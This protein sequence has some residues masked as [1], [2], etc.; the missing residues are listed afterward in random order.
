M[1]HVYAVDQGLGLQNET[2]DAVHYDDAT[3]LLLIIKGG[4][5]FAYDLSTSAGGGVW[6]PEA[7]PEG[8]GRV[9]DR[10]GT[11][12]RHDQLV[13]TY[14]LQEGPGVR[15]MRC[16]LDRQM[17]ALCRSLSL[18]EL[19]DLCTG[20]ISVHTL[21]GGTPTAPPS[22]SP[23]SPM[24]P[25][26][27]SATISPE[28]RPP[29]PLSPA[30]LNLTWGRL[31]GKSRSNKA[32]STGTAS[33]HA[34]SNTGGGGTGDLRAE[35]GGV[36]W[37]YVTPA[38]H[39][40]VTPPLGGD[41]TTQRRSSPLAA[42]VSASSPAAST[43]GAS[44]QGR[45]PRSLDVAEGGEGALGGNGG[46]GTKGGYVDKDGVYCSRSSSS[47]V[48]GGGGSSVDGGTQGSGGLLG[49]LMG[50]YFGAGSSS[51]PAHKGPSPSPAAWPLS[52]GS[53][54]TELNH[55]SGVQSPSAQQQQHQQL[56]QSPES[57]AAAAAAA[58][59]VSV[60]LGLVFSEAPGAE[61]VLAGT[62]GLEL[63]VLAPKKQGPCQY[64]LN[65]LNLVPQSFLHHP[66]DFRSS[67][68]QS[69]G[70]LVGLITLPSFTL[71]SPSLGT[72]PAAST[73]L[74][75]D[76]P[77]NLL[78]AEG[79][80]TSQLARPNLLPPEPRT[81]TPSSMFNPPTAGPA[82]SQ[83]GSSQLGVGAPGH[84]QQQQQQQG[85]PSDQA[86]WAGGG[87]G[88]SGWGSGIGAAA[89]PT[90]AAGLGGSGSWGELRGLPNPFCVQGASGSAGPLRLLRLYNCVFACHISEHTTTTVTTTRT[91]KLSA[92]H[93]RGGNNNSSDNSAPVGAEDKIRCG[94]A[95]APARTAAPAQP[96]GVLDADAETVTKTTTTVLLRLYRFFTDSVKLQHTYALHTYVHTHGRPQGQ[97]QGVNACT[98]STSSSTSSGSGC[99]SSIALS[100]VDNVLVV[101]MENARRVVLIDILADPSQPLTPPMPLSLLQ[102]PRIQAVSSL[103]ALRGAVSY[104]G[105]SS[106]SSSSSPTATKTLGTVTPAGGA[107]TSSFGITHSSSSAAAVAVAQIVPLE[108]LSSGEDGG[109]HASVDRNTTA[110]ATHSAA[111]AGSGG[112]DVLRPSWRSYLP[113]LLV[114][115]SKQGVYR[116][117]L[118]LHTAAASIPDPAAATAFLLRRRA[119]RVHAQRLQLWPLLSP[120][121]SYLS[122]APTTPSAIEVERQ[123]E[124]LS[125]PP[126]TTKGGWVVLG[127]GEGAETRPL[128]CHGYLTPPKLLV[129]ELVRNLMQDRA[130]MSVLRRVFAHL[131]FAFAEVVGPNTTPKPST[132]GSPPASASP[133]TAAAAAAGA[134]AAAAP[135]TEARQGGDPTT[136]A[137]IFAQDYASSS[138]C[139][140]FANPSLLPPTAWC[141]L[142]P[143]EVAGACF[144]WA[145]ET[146]AL[147]ALGLQAVLAEFAAAASTA[148]VPVPLPLQR[149]WLDLLL[150]VYPP[151][152][153]H[154]PPCSHFIR[155]IASNPT[156][157]TATL[158]PTVLTEQ[159][160]TPPP[161]QPHLLA[162]LLYCQ[163]GAVDP[164]LADHLEGML[165]R[166]CATTPLPAPLLRMLQAAQGKGAEGDWDELCGGIWE[167]DDLLWE[168]QGAS[169]IRRPPATV[170]AAHKLAHAA[171]NGSLGLR[172]NSA[173]AS[174][175]AQRARQ[176]L[177]QQQQQVLRGSQGGSSGAAA[178]ARRSAVQPAATQP[179]GGEATPPPTT[180]ATPSAP[181]AAA[182]SAAASDAHP[183]SAATHPTSHTLAY[184]SAPNAAPTV[185]HQGAPA[186]QPGLQHPSA[187]APAAGAAASAAA[188]AASADTRAAQDAAALVQALLKGG[189]ITRA[190]RTARDLLHFLRPTH[191][192]GAGGT[193]TSSGGSNGGGVVSA[194]LAGVQQQQQ[195]QQHHA[196][197]SSAAPSTPAFDGTAAA[198]N[199]LTSASTAATAAGPSTSDGSDGAGV[200]ETSANAA[201]TLWLALPLEV[202]AAAAHTGNTVLAAAVYRCF[203]PYLTSTFPSWESVEFSMGLFS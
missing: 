1:S 175:R 68:R 180:P 99:S 161:L 108:E 196:S 130:P 21:S 155:Y 138:C 162:A 39:Q 12:P 77:P 63:C 141:V 82:P 115:C 9:R 34:S 112:V 90:A 69:R 40:L 203:A 120:S 189:H 159:L 15:A 59:G 44:P 102:P 86:W 143:E 111:H 153:P 57:A 116:L 23:K 20:N 62:G 11:G 160:H 200:S 18:V 121:S 157:L 7:A 67:A 83:V 122:S 201:P 33:S 49:S 174:A 30:R 193:A 158:T 85:A 156:S 134:A 154:Q 2:V 93:S 66:N 109:A 8:A 25:L 114:D 97:Q 28:P 181:A 36:L 202:L 186:P 14:P 145:L 4:V 56:H 113:N 194:I 87:G 29:S 47:S 170:A 17:L 131:C 178:G 173:A 135:S 76:S 182:P 92:A 171:W 72:A 104:S 51:V 136:I 37:G 94:D 172:A 81:Q 50:D 78:A 10:A 35:G 140:P 53:G 148:R 106:S 132:A 128:D 179:G 79:P 166:F 133:S 13:W 84:P 176:Q 144:G 183:G 64:S 137:A 70:G 58:A 46:A 126:C 88:D 124:G 73:S 52:I 32:S 91:T 27:T 55:H 198:P 151:A 149:L 45:S 95:T 6:G 192:Q 16:S 75:D 184:P 54:Q 146:G 105:A 24:L 185:V 197:T 152:G 125:T 199:E 119:S 65:H 5:V 26:S 80:R 48:N 127:G 190:A 41:A 19:V 168:E 71:T 103:S 61:I 3:S 96:H 89:A 117:V 110:M 31:F 139:L 177:Q 107:G 165:A 195:Q 60:L 150:L 167:D 43:A 98:S 169:P 142:T 100:V 164:S 129:L 187:S 188:A 74:L 101:Q 38:P 123:R 42:S 118:D 191:P 22:P 163:W 147:D